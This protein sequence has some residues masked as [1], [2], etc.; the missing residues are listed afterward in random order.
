MHLFTGR[1]RLTPKERKKAKR[2]DGK[3]SEAEKGDGG[4]SRAW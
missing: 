4:N 3:A 2:N 1:K